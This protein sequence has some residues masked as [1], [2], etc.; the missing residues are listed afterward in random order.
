MTSKMEFEFMK[1]FKIAALIRVALSRAHTSAEAQFGL[2]DS[3]IFQDPCNISRDTNKNLQKSMLK[4]VWKKKILDLSLDLD[5]DQKLM[6]SILDWDQSSVQVSS[7][8]H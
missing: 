1:P 2:I 3:F 6:K 7:K 4:K 5:L 8:F